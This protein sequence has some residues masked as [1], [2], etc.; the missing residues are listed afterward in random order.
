MN[1]KV[2]R[3]VHS[4]RCGRSLARL[5]VTIRSLMSSTISLQPRP[6]Y[7]RIGS[8]R[9]NPQTTIMYRIQNIPTHSNPSLHPR[10]L[11]W[12]V[13]V[14]LRR[15][16]A[17]VPACVYPPHYRVSL[18]HIMCCFATLSSGA[19]YKGGDRDKQHLERH[20]LSRQAAQHSTAQKSTHVIYKR[21][22]GQER[23]CSGGSSCG[24]CRERCWRG[25]LC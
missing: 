6:L 11:S 19:Q 15:F 5:P 4:R 23:T 20:L 24:A 18:Q 8:N 2:L 9:G 17:L 12:A 16:P 7:T 10:H 3:A 14:C 21:L 22:G 25:T 1:P 13:C